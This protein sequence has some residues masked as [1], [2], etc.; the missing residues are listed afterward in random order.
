MQTNNFIVHKWLSYIRV[1]SV[2]TRREG[3]AELHI[4]VS[5]V[6]LQTVQK[7]SYAEFIYIYICL[8][9]C[10]YFYMWGRGFLNGSR[11]HHTM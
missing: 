11:G 9:E 10:V 7:H 3:G 6:L 2:Y 1:I 8:Y 5:T 4:E